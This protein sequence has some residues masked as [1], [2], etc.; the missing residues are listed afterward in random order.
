MRS[1]SALGGTLA[2]AVLSGCATAPSF[3]PAAPMMGDAVVEAGIGPHAGFGRESM[4]VGSTVWA[5]GQVSEGVSFFLR[6]SAADF[7]S[8]QGDQAPLDDVLASGGGGIRWTA[9]YLDHLILGAEGTLEYEQR[10][11][12]LAEQLVI[13]TVGLPVAEQAMEGLWVYT[14]LQLGIAIP[15]VEDSRGPFFGYQEVPLGVAWQ[16]LPWLLV[17][18]EGGLFLPLAGGYGAVA[19]AV[20]L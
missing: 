4:A 3:R 14:D 9:R 11:G 16:P 6:G 1:A 5:S 7:F 2:F 12:P 10:S 20:R 19:V 15:L 17:V 13:G 18:G 8:Y